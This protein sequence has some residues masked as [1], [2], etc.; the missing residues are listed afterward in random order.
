MTPA[1]IPGLICALVLGGI[2]VAGLTP[3]RRPPNGVTWLG[4]E[5]GLH[6][7]RYGTVWS[8]GE[9]HAAAAQNESECS[10]EI[11]LQ[12][13]IASA[14]S[15]VLAFYTPQ[16]PLHLSL[17]Q[18]R[19]LFIIIRETQDDS[20]G[21]QVIGLA[22]VL[23]P[24]KPAFITVTSGPQKTSIYVDGNLKKQF[25][26]FRMGGDCAGRLVAGTSP[27]ENNSWSGDIRALA[28]YQRELTPEQVFQHFD[29]WT[30]QGRPLISPDDNPMAVY[31]F[32]ERAGNVVHE[33]THHGIELYIPRHFSLLRQRFLEP[34]WKEFKPGR[35]Y[36]ADIAVNIAGFIPLGLVF[37]AYWSSVRPIKYPVV[38]TVALGFAVSLTIEVLQSYLPTRDSGTTDLITNTMGTFVGVKIYSLRTVRDLLAKIF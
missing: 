29:T 14:S 33:A 17:H 4:N 7:G 24:T 31:L 5:N 22:D 18:Y 15:T 34:F 28:I 37:C 3:F 21:R 16:S 27:V 38:A 10:L 23:R 9:F 13:S 25:P 32:D 6:F 26:L 19:T 1:R 36:W 20:K 35:D 11:S 2:F 12:P 30:R 8:S